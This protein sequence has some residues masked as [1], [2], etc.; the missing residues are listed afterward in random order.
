MC[1]SSALNARAFTCTTLDACSAVVFLLQILMHGQGSLSVF[2]SACEFKC[3]IDICV[4][5]Q[6]K[7]EA[8]TYMYCHMMY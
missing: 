6:G 3:K 4:I 8:T 1:H 5:V 7:K 2:K